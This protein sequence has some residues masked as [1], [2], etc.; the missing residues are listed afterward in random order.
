M[1]IQLPPAVKAGPSRGVLAAGWRVALRL[2]NGVAEIDLSEANFRSDD[3]WAR[4][5][6]YGLLTGQSG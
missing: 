5:L 1:S 4:P 3:V 2:G 6:H